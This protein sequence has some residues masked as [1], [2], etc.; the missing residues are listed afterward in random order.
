ML[1]NAQYYYYFYKKKKKKRKKERD[2]KIL[3]HAQSLIAT[4]A[5]LY[6]K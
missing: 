6:K 3:I 2:K 1:K 4:Y 5:N